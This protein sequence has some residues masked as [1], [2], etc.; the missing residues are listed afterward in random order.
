MAQQKRLWTLLALLLLCALVPLTAFAAGETSGQCGDNAFWSYDAETKTFTINGSGEM[1][2][3]AYSTPWDSYKSEMENAIVEDGITLIGESAFVNCSVL[4]TLVIGKSV[5]EINRYAFRSD[6]EAYQ[7]NYTVA[8]LESITVSEENEYF[9]SRDNVLFDKEQTRLILY[10][11]GCTDTEYTFP[12]TVRTVAYKAFSE[13]NSLEKI[14]MNDGL[15]NIEAEAFKNCL[16]LAEALLPDSVANISTQIFNGTPFYENTE[17]R[18]NGVLYN[19]KWVI[20]IDPQ[21]VT[22]NIKDGTYGFASDCIPS[23]LFSNKPQIQTV[24]LPASIVNIAHSLI[25]GCP[26]LKSISVDADNP[27]YTSE[28]GIL[29]NK[30]KTAL[31]RLPPQFALTSFS[32]PETVTE[33]G[34]YACDSCKNLQTVLFPAGLKKVGAHAFDN[35]KNLVNALL[36][37]GVED[38]D[39]YAFDDCSKLAN[40]RIPASV[41]RIGYD[42]F[43]FTAFYNDDTAWED[44]KYLYLDDCL[45]CARDGEDVKDFAVRKGTRLIAEFTFYYNY[46]DMTELTLPESLVYIGKEAFYHPSNIETVYIYQTPEQWASVSI[47]ERNEN[48]TKA[49]IVY[50]PFTHSKAVRT[51]DSDTSVTVSAF[52]V[53]CGAYIFAAGYES[54]K[55]TNIQVQA[56]AGS[57]AIFTLKG[58]PDAV[59]IFVLDENLSPF[60]QTPEEITANQILDLVTE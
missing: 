27:L 58:T 42:V 7:K 57:N 30:D 44:G 3:Y 43:S 21:T 14:H 23:G 49:N 10:P 17:N 5:S 18:E 45:L 52:N 15:L 4:K 53:P 31:L 24:F 32:I 37:D 56:Y 8:P 9:C 2:R 26:N 25:A 46:T 19:G 38:I 33:I 48:L 55:L 47:G 59:K 36:P 60:V 50:M 34:N 41:T 11:A 1:Y 54:G 16:S 29:Y 39:E 20:Y 28:N 51:T 35:C 12:E 6:M 13:S 40:I 22:L